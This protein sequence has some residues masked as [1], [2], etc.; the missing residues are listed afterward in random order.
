MFFL[1]A[2]KKKNIKNCY[3]CKNWRMQT[4]YRFGLKMENGELNP[5]NLNFSPL[6]TIRIKFHQLAKSNLRR[7]NESLLNLSYVI[8]TWFFSLSTHDLNLVRNFNVQDFN[9][10]N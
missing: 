4:D 2:N 7:F 8:V 3:T 6:N 5:S 1:I 10:F 9:L